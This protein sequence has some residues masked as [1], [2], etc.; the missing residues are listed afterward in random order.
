[1][2]A[3]VKKTIAMGSVAGLVGSIGVVEFAE[4]AYATETCYANVNHPWLDGGDVFFDG[5]AG[6]SAPATSIDILM[7]IQARVHGSGKPFANVGDGGT[8][9]NATPPG[10]A[11]ESWGI[12]CLSGQYDYRGLMSVQDRDRQL[13]DNYAGYSTAITF[14]CK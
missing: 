5:T 9:A 8:F 3:G 10:G 2:R 4:P 13:Q 11:Y 14:S 1:M 12:T 6:C 7:R